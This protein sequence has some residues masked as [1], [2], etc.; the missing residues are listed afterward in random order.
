MMGE[1][2]EG[3][4]LD[5]LESVELVARAKRGEVECVEALFK[6]YRPRLLRLARRSMGQRRLTC[7]PSDIVQSTLRRA[8]LQWDDF[9]P[10]HERA[11]AG[12]FA[13][14]LKNT[15]ASQHR[16]EGAAKRGNG[17][18]PSELDECDDALDL[19]NQRGSVLDEL[20]EDDLAA[21]VWSSLSS[22]D[23]QLVRSRL[24]LEED[25]DGVAQNTGISNAECARKRYSRLITRLKQDLSRRDS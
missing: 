15:I 16:R 4:D 9:E 13:V 12:W 10:E 8:T 3:E 20:A 22:E 7:E 11:I 21:R 6:R 17:V 2:E 5:E 14:I 24:E 23:L 18:S 25:W 19:P 1:S